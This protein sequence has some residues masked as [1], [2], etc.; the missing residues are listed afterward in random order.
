[1]ALREVLPISP[2]GI[3]S[4][5]LCSWTSPSLQH[6]PIFQKSLWHTRVMHCL[7]QKIIVGSITSLWM[8]NLWFFP[9]DLFSIFPEVHG[10]PITFSLLLYTLVAL[11]IIPVLPVRLHG[12]LSLQFTMLSFCF[13]QKIFLMPPILLSSNVFYF[14][15]FA[16]SSQR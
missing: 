9:L 12:K 14:L 7:R 1:M 8:S 11:F 6:L 13:S 2:S 4:L 10:K 15:P 5:R 3:F 16:I